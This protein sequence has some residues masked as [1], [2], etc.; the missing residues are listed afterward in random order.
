VIPQLAGRIAVA[1]TVWAHRHGHH[2]YLSTGCLHGDHAYCQTQAR[3]YDGTVKTAAVC[4]FC[5]EGDDRGGSCVCHCHR[6]A[7]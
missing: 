5:S 4:K 6:E 3:R 2:R 1:L 7:P